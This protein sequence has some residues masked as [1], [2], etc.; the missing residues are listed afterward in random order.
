MVRRSAILV[1]AL[2]VACESLNGVRDGTYTSPDGAFSMPVP[3][4][5][6][7]LAIENGGAPPAGSAR[8]GYVSFHDD[9]GHV[10]S[11]TYE[12]VAPELAA[13]FAGGEHADESLSAF[14]RE[15]FLPQ[16][17]QRSPG[18]CITHESTLQLKDGTRALFAVLEIPGGSPMVVA[19]EQHPDG[20]RLDTTRAHLFLLHGDLFLTLSAA[21]DLAP[22]AGG[23]AHPAPSAEDLERWKNVLAQLYASM[24]FS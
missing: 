20:R 11:I 13:V 5:S 14:L 4:L 17:A 3:R 9:F 15:K 10:R 7:G 23:A 21:D 1:L 8:K 18:A 16:L 12:Q 19:D 2:C 22:D 6:A 24:R